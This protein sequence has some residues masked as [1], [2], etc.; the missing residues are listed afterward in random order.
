MY[1]TFLVDAETK[2]RRH[3]LAPEGAEDLPYTFFFT[4]NTCSLKKCK[5]KK[6]SAFL[7]K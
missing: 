5:G 2:K 1:G 6:Y 3:G 4:M 7:Q